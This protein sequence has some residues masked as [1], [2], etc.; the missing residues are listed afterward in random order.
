MG[1]IDW[2]PTAE[3]ILASAGYDHLLIIWNAARG[4][5]LSVIQCHQDTIFSM[6][7]NRSVSCH[8]Y[9]FHTYFTWEIAGTAHC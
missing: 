5:A 7:F 9:N 4:L 8:T 2:H 6:S 3:N 1:L